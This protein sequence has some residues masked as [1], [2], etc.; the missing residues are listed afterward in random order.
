L[1]LL[2]LSLNDNST[3]AATFSPTPGAPADTQGQATILDND[4]PIVTVTQTGIIT[5]RDSGTADAVFTITLRNAN[6]VIAPSAQDVTVNFSTTDGTATSPTDFTPVTGS[7][8]IAAGQATGTIEVPIVGDTVDEENETFTLKLS[9]PTAGQAGFQLGATLTT[10]TLTATITD[11]DTASISFTGDNSG[12]VEVNE[13]TAT[14]TF[15]VGLST[16][17]DRTVTVNYTVTGAGPNPATVGSDFTSTS[18]TLTFV[19]GDTE[20]T[21]TVPILNDALDE[22]NEQFTVTLSM[23]TP[24][25]T[26]ITDATAVGTIID[27]DGT[28]SLS[29]NDVTV[30]EGTG[31][32]TTA[33]F[34]VTLSPASGQVVTVNVATADGTATSPDDFTA[35]PATTLTFNPGE[36]TKT[37]S[38]TINPDDIDEPVQTFSVNLTNEFNATITRPFV[39]RDIGNGDCWAV[40]GDGADAL[41]VA[42]RPS[43]PP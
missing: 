8:I 9:L 24:G 37:F 34:T 31:G 23:A 19:P 15:P 20:E 40:V 12:D 36:T 5:E 28:P 32:A 39:N 30:T 42:R 6:G 2:N 29:I 26:T 17:S 41:R 11:D 3:G 14:A 4:G 18:G 10:P 35:R 7:V 22:T 33:T 25:G 13:A 43:R 21:I 1:S 16:T 38:V 27:E